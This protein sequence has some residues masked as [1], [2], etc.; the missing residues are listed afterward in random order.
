MKTFIAFLCSIVYVSLCFGQAKIKVTKDSLA[1]REKYEVLKSN[2]KIKQGSYTLSVISSGKILT[3]GSYKNN[4]KN[5]QW[6]EYNNDGYTIVEGSYKNG[7]KVGEW[8]Y[9]GK[10][11]EILNKYNFDTHRLT[12]HKD[13]PAER[14]VYYKILRGKDT[15]STTMDRPPIYLGGNEIMLRN[16]MYNLQYPAKALEAKVYG[17][18]IVE[19]TIDEQGHPHDFKAVQKLGYGLDEEALQVISS[20]PEEWVPG[21]LNGKTVPVILQLP[22]N[23]KVQ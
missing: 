9:Y 10:L 16:L 12:Y 15:I 19:F 22:V 8:S 1:F 17:R 21:V 6:H 2:P 5:G 11:W 13:D 14:T 23:F 4:L 7:K 3:S 20:I 18:V